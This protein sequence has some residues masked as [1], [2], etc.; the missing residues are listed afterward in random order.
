MKMNTGGSSHHAGRASLRAHERTRW[1][2]RS[3]RPHSTSGSAIIDTANSH[4][5]NH[6]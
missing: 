5:M 2:P 6:R 3:V 4:R 1:E